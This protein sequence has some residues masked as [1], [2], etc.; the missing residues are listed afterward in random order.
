MLVSSASRDAGQ[1][2]TYSREFLQAVA[3]D[4]RLFERIAQVRP[5]I[6]RTL[7]ILLGDL[8]DLLDLPTGV[9]KAL[10]ERIRRIG[11]TV[12]ARADRAS[13]DADAE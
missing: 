2:S 6:I 4:R 1:P 12:M 7:L 3:A 8:E 13:G 11:E 9:Q 5:G 10:G